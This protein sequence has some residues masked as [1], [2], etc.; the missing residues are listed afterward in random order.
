MAF[1]GNEEHT[2]SFEEAKELKDN[3]QKS[4]S[5]GDILA[6]YY[7]KTFLLS[8]LNQEGC[9][10]IRV[11]NG[12]KEDGKL[13]LVIVGVKTDGNDLTEGIM[14]NRSVPCPPYCGSPW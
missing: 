8:V 10:G 7:G 12:R 6:F 13:E 5:P 1:T 2:I 11:Y 3:Y 4:M 14:G 9:V